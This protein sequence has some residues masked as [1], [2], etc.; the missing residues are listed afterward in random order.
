MCYYL[1]DFSQTNGKIKEEKKGKKIL[2][3]R[4]NNKNLQAL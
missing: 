4:I 2:S 1:C 3:S